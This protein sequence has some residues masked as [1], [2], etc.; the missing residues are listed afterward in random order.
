ML[1]ASPDAIEFRDG[2][3]Y[4]EGFDSLDIAELLLELSQEFGSGDGES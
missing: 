3:I 4:I 1:G 2:A